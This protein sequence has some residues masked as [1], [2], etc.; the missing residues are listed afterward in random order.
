MRVARGKATATITMITTT[1]TSVALGAVAHRP[2]CLTIVH[3]GATTA[4]TNM[5]WKS[6]EARGNMY[7][8]V[9]P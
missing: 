7:E 6:G 9:G 1:T 5:A 3:I 4:T 8:V 2:V